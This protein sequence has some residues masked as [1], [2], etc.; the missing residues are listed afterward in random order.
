VA[1]ASAG[2]QRSPDPA[3]QPS[4]GGV[5]HSNIAAQEAQ[6]RIIEQEK[7]YHASWRHSMRDHASA[8]STT[9]AGDVS[10]TFMF[11]LSP[12]GSA[13]RCTFRRMRLRSWARRRCGR[14]RARDPDRTFPASDA[15]RNRL[16][17][18]SRTLLTEIDFPTRMA[19]SIRIYCTVELFIPARPSMIIPAD[20]VVSIKMAACRGGR[21]RTARLQKITIARDFGKKLRCTRRQA[22]RSGH[23]QSMVTWWT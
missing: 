19:R 2:R 18:G 11:M 9:A 17:P 21:E 12:D 16:Q 14:A 8:T 1:D 7:A 4:R 10:S 5:A 3:G 15:H 22:G 6:I 20:A 23:P 13:P